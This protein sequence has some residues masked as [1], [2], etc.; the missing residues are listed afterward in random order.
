MTLSAIHLL[1]AADEKEKSAIKSKLNATG[2]SKKGLAEMLRAHGS[3]EYAQR[4]AQQFVEKA[5][6]TLADLKESDAKDALIE[7]ARFAAN[8]VV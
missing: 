5:V 3:L 7:T 4:R 6:Q 2:E 8:R 1:S